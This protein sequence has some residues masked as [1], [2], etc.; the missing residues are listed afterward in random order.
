METSRTF[1]NIIRVAFI[2]V[3]TSYILHM[4]VTDIYHQCNDNKYLYILV[5]K[6]CYIEV[7]AIA[8]RGMYTFC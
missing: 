1:G 4:Q 8:K 2:S 7:V 6:V 5:L 3:Q